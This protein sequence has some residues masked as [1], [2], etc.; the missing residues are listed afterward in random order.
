MSSIG[1]ARKNCPTSSSNYDYFVNL[2][3]FCL[4]YPFFS[5]SWSRF[6]SC[7]ARRSRHRITTFYKTLSASF[8]LLSDSLTKSFMYTRDSD[9]PP[10]YYSIS[11]SIDEQCS[12]LSSK[13]SIRVSKSDTISRHFVKMSVNKVVNVSILQSVFPYVSSWSVTHCWSQR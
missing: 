8:L 4:N 5:C 2:R 3:R 10:V 12:F 1:P 13:L 11:S 9:D 7:S 6:I